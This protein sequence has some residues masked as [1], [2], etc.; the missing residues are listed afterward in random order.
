[1]LAAVVANENGRRRESDRGFSTAELMALMPGLDDF[2]KAQ[3]LFLIG[4]NRMN[5]IALA[6]RTWQTAR[7]APIARV[8]MA[9]AT[10]GEDG[11]VV[12]ELVEL[13]EQASANANAETNASA[14]GDI[15]PAYA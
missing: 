6:I 12:E 7:P 14:G 8:A 3:Q 5:A 13:A 1:M 11:A 4:E 9:Y 15:G 2:E 10:M